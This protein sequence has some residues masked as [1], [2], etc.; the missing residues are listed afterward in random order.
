MA[1]IMDSTDDHP[2]VVDL[3]KSLTSPPTIMVS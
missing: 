2:A 1:F 3:V